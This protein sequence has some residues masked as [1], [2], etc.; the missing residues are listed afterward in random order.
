MKWMDLGHLLLKRKKQF[1]SR[2]FKA[3][4]NS[5]ALFLV[6]H[7]HSI[8]E[9]TPPPLRPDGPFVG[10]ADLRHNLLDKIGG[11][12]QKVW[13]ASEQ[14]TDGEIVAALSVAKYRQLDV[15]VLL[16]KEKMRSYASKF[17]FLRQNQVSVYEKPSSLALGES[18]VIVIDN[19]VLVVNSALDFLTD[20]KVLYM[21]SAAEP[22][23]SQ[24]LSAFRRIRTGY[25]D[26][27]PVSES[28]SPTANGQVAGAKNSGAAPS[29]FSDRPTESAPGP[30]VKSDDSSPFTYSRNER[31]APPGVPKKLPNKTVLQLR[32]ERQEDNPPNQGERH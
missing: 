5:I 14:L 32:E 15:V 24:T 13:V 6:F 30:G 22:I 4:T 2:A 10:F 11:A 16:G 23:K 1:R 3:G 7:W 29:Q 26:N 12:K 31:K 27:M 21:Q 20:R 25:S 17:A 18:S 19:E 28:T 8:A 9:A